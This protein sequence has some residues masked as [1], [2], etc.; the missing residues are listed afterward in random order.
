MNQINKLMITI[1]KTD[2]DGWN[3]KTKIVLYTRCCKE[4]IIRIQNGKRRALKCIFCMGN[5]SD[6]F[7]DYDGNI[8]PIK[9]A[10]R[11]H[12]FSDRATNDEYGNK[13]KIPNGIEFDTDAHAGLIDSSLLRDKSLV[14]FWFKCTNSNG[15]HPPF[16]VTPQQLSK[17]IGCP[18]CGGNSSQEREFSESMLS[19]GWIFERQKTFRGCANEIALRFDFFITDIDSHCRTVIRSKLPILI[20]LDD[21]SH[22]L[23]SSMKRDMIKDEFVQKNNLLLY[24]LK[25]KRSETGEEIMIRLIAKMGRDA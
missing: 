24:R 15:L 25:T 5:R 20:E 14:P 12:Y 8:D 10:Q 2:D 16:M 4:C 7:E 17:R 13:I 11:I 3:R 1:R 21:V 19:R 22:N 9:Q 23:G 18:I 6:W